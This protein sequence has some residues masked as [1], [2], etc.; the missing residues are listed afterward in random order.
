MLSII[1]APLTPQR[2][3]LIWAMASLF[4]AALL[5]PDA[6]EVVALETPPFVVWLVGFR[7]AAILWSF[8]RLFVPGEWP[9]AVRLPS[10]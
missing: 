10:D 6:R 3:I 1:A 8:A 7:I 5:L 4:L 2:L 9:N